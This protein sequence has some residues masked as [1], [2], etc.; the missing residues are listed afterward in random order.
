LGQAKALNG[1]RLDRCLALH[2]QIPDLIDRVSTWESADHTDDSNG[3]RRVLGQVIGAVNIADSANTSN[4]TV[5]MTVDVAVIEDFLPLWLRV[6]KV[7]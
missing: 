5:D 2:N 6:F 7:A 4:V 1:S 3:M